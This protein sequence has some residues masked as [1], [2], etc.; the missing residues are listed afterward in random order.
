MPGGTRGFDPGRLRALRGDRG[1]TQAELA[2]G[3]GVRRTYLV[4]WERLGG[5]ATAPT[6]PM[7]RRLADVLQVRPCDLTCIEPEQAL[8]SDLRAWAGLSQPD[9]A[10][11]LQVP[12]TTLSAVERGQRPLHASLAE[13]LTV[14]LGVTV[15]EIQRAYDLAR[16]GSVDSAG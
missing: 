14:Y 2:K 16:Q 12:E 7:L 4:Q 5:R 15:D 11:A 13:R 6:A 10:R 8:L 9:L 3:V 1:L